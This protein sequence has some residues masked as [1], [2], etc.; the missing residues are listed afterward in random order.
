M[1]VLSSKKIS[2]SA[3]NKVC[4]IG[5]D[6]AAKISLYFSPVIPPFRVKIVTAENYD[7][8]AHIMADPSPFLTDGGKQS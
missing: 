1:G 3:G 4:I 7:T 8:V 6:L 5:M 2:S